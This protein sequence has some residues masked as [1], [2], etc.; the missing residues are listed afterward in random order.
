MDQGQ[1][2][3]NK[4]FLPDA[5]DITTGSSSVK[6]GIID[7]GID[8]GHND[9][10]GRVNTTLSRYYSL[11]EQPDEETDE[12]TEGENNG[13]CPEVLE[14]GEGHGS[15]VAGIIGALSDNYQ[16]MVGV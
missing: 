6:V 3:I 5:W 2:A 11:S 9:L 7:S 15:R 8:T 12:E 1:W 10:I 13:N 14:D 16:G 4:I